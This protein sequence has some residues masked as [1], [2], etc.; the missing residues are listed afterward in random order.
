MMYLLSFL[1]CIKIICI[2]HKLTFQGICNDGDVRLEGGDWE[3]EGRIEVCYTG[4]WE[5]LCDDHVD[6][7]VA[8][9]VCRQ[10]G[11]SLHSKSTTLSLV[12]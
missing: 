12:Q 2:T 6:D 4:E 3:Y 8:E 9:V 7:S 10:L 5:T 1:Q 11:F